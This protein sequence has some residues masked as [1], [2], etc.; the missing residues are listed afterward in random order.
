MTALI[1]RREFITLLGGAAA[2]WPIAARAQQPGK[3]PIIGFLGAATLRPSPWAAPFVQR[4]RELGWVEGRNPR[5]R[6]SMGGRTTRAICGNRS[7]IRPSQG[8]CHRHASAG[9]TIAAKRATSSSRLCSPCWGPG[10]GRGLVATWR[11]RAATLPACLFRRPIRLASGSKFCGRSHPISAKW[12]SWA[13]SVIR[14]LCWRW[15]RFEVAA[16]TLGLENVPWK[17][18]EPR[19]SRRP[20]STQ[21]PRTDALYVAPD[22]L[23]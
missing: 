23:L 21:W 15:G 2:A 12:R 8:R 16:R 4:L 7:R 3:Q 18:V 10:C 6:I 13:M 17:F 9:P 1:G 22:P 14:L 11:G 20:S 19:T 5:D